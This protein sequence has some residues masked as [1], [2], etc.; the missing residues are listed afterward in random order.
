MDATHFREKAAR[1][2]EM[3]QTGDDVRLSQMLLEVAI[4]LDAEAEAIDAGA[5][6][7]RRRFPRG[8]ILDRAVLRTGGPMPD[9]RPVQIINLSLGGAKFRIDRPQTPGSKVTLELPSHQL[10]LDGTILRMRGTEAAMAFNS[11]SRCD[12]GL[13]RLLQP[14]PLP[15]Y[16]PAE[17]P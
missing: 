15:E 8:A 13:T 17:S 6:E 7:E 10:R 16:A 1:A 9:T 3:A 12:A 2:R 11:A 14:E 5:D 4:D